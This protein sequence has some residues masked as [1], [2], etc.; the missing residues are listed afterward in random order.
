MPG[1]RIPGG[2]PPSRWQISL[3]HSYQIQDEILIAP[4][5]PILDRLNGSATSSI[6]GTARHRVE[7]SGG[8]FYKG[9]GLRVEGNYR[10]A[11]RVDGSALTSSGDLRFGSLTS[12]NLRLFTN[13]DDRGKLTQ[14]FKFLKGTRLVLRVDNLLNDIIDVRDENGQ[15]PLSYQPGFIDPVGRYFEF[16]VVKRF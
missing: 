14:K 15:V 2:G 10:S 11:T 7:L 12:L 1:G 16:A 6:G 13:L 9:M 8:L 4:G 5:V 3:Y